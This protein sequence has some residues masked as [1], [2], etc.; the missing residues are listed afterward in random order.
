MWRNR[1]FQAS[2][3]PYACLEVSFTFNK[4]FSEIWNWNF[5][6]KCDVI[7][8]GNERCKHYRKVHKSTPLYSV[9]L[10]D[11]CWSKINKWTLPNIPVGLFAMITNSIVIT[12][13]SLSKVLRKNIPMIL[14]ANMA[15]G[16]FLQG[17]YLVIVTITRNF[18]SSF[19]YF[20]MRVPYF[21][22]SL[23]V[24]FYAAQSF[25][26]LVCFLVTV[27][28][29]LCIVYSMQPEIRITQSISKILL[30]LV[31]LLVLVAVSLP[32]AI[33]MKISYYKNHACVVVLT[34]VRSTG[35]SSGNIRYGECLAYCGFAFYLMTYVLYAHIFCT[36][37]KS[38]FNIGLKR[39][40]KMAKRIMLVITTNLFFFLIPLIVGYIDKYWIKFIERNTVTSFVYWYTFSYFCF[41]V[42]SCLNPILYPFRNEKFQT[43]FR[44]LFKCKVRVSN[45]SNDTNLQLEGNKVCS[46]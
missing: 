1:T 7:F 42:N 39:E 18:M 15:I 23:V 30:A 32:F 45:F 3:F 10:K 22:S 2:L 27:E 38:S 41:G 6:L 8:E 9:A 43:E 19:Q 14:L 28:R 33:N 46:N 24:L 12:T 29:Y 37:R 35:S 11:V 44:R 21:C 36:V 16:D 34:D 26:V 20:E 5:S 4:S 31:W 13:V 17:L 25:T 40:G